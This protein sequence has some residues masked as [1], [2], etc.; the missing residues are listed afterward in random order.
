MLAGI[1]PK[2]GPTE[3]R[4]LTAATRMALRSTSPFAPGALAAL[5]AWFTIAQV[6]DVLYDTKV[7]YVLWFSLALATW[8]EPPLA[9]S[10]G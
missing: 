3:P 2:R 4:L 6:H 1:Q 5:A 7:M 10:A 9:T 8:R